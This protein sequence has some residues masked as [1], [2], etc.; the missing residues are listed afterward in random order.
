MSDKKYHIPVASVWNL[1]EIK[2]QQFSHPD[3]V[4]HRPE[5]PSLQ[6]NKYRNRYMIGTGSVKV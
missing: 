1:Q 2:S 6:F 4:S 3:G 5:N